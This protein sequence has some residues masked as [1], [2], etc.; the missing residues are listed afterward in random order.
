MSLSLWWGSGQKVFLA[1]VPTLPIA[2]VNAVLILDIWYLSRRKVSCPSWVT[3]RFLLEVCFKHLFLVDMELNQSAPYAANI[4]SCFIMDLIR[5]AFFLGWLWL[6]GLSKTS[7]FLMFDVINKR[8]DILDTADN[9]DGDDANKKSINNQEDTFDA[10]KDIGDDLDTNKMTPL[11]GFIFF[12]TST[13]TYRSF[14]QLQSS[15]VG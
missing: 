13:L 2:S 8:D 14:F 11:D 3:G 12:D 5:W 6:S 9:D 15:L 7:L 10:V 1:A 4:G